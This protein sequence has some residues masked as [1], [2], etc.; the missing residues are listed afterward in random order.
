MAAPL[1]TSA[2][3]DLETLTPEQAW[4]LWQPVSDEYIRRYEA[5]QP[6]PIDLLAEEMGVPLAVC[7]LVPRDEEEEAAAHGW[8]EALLGD[9]GDALE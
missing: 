6:I 7:D 1:Q 9:V 8:S 5:G 2:A 4:E 3:I